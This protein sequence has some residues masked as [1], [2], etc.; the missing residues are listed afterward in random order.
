MR[1]GALWNTVDGSG[2][3]D[4]LPSWFYETGLRNRLRVSVSKNTTGHSDL[5]HLLQTYFFEDT[6]TGD[7]PESASGVAAN[8]KQQMTRP[9]NIEGSAMVHTVR[10]ILLVAVNLA[11]QAPK[12][13]T[14]SH[15]VQ[16]AP[17]SLAPCFNHRDCSPTNGSQTC[18]GI[19][20]QPPKA[21][22][23]AHSLGTTVPNVGTSTLMSAVLCV[24]MHS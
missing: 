23:T 7:T 19:G 5:L 10:M 17:A 18:A 6:L 11:E 9:G 22:E 4:R 21:G 2:F 13:G 24:V 20:G 14:Q 12:Y 8:E 1:P 16:K 3:G 15:R